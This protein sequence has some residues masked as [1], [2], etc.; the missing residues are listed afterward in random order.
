MVVRA[1]LGTGF[2]VIAGPDTQVN[3]GDRLGI[4]YRCLIINT[5]SAATSMRPALSAS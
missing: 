5:R 3:G 2:S 1:P 4:E